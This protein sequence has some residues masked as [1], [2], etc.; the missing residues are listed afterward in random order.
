MKVLYIFPHPRAHLPRHKILKGCLENS[1]PDTL[2]LGLTHLQNFNIGY[3]LLDAG[4]FL[5][6]IRALLMTKGYDLV[7]CKDATSGLLLGLLKKWHLLKK[8]LI[9]LD[10]V[11]H[12][13]IVGARLRFLRYIVS[14]FNRVIYCT[15]SLKKLLREYF[16]VP[17]ASLKY[18]P[19][20]VDDVFFKPRK[21]ETQTFIF[22]AGDNDRD[23]TTLAQAT[24]GTGL[25]LKIAT[26]R[27]IKGSFD[28]E[29]LPGLKPLS[30]R[31]EYAQAKFIV[32]PLYNVPSASGAT[33]LLESMAMAKATIVSDSCGIRDFVQDGH[34]AIVVQ[35]QDVPSLRKAIIYLNENSQERVRLGRNARHTVEQHFN[36]KKQAKAL[37]EVYRKVLTR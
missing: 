36:T 20:A 24:Q 6:Q 29:L 12:E 35:A 10:I 32:V 13:H 18:I 16:K 11:V 30:L 7:V 19:W 17:E 23:Y 28:I 33:A 14:G 3:G 26:N 25:K 34:N 37:V 8:P 22:S 1:Y 2:L 21:A 31:E 27:T 15:P 9:L 5:G 4:T